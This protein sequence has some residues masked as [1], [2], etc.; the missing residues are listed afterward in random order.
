[1]SNFDLRKFLAEQKTAKVNN[2]KEETIKE[3]DAGVVAV[4][5]PIVMS[6]VAAG[7][8]KLG[9]DKIMQA[10][11]RIDKDKFNKFV[12]KYAS[13]F[14][15]GHHK[16]MEEADHDMEE[17]LNE[18]HDK[19]M[20][21][22]HDEMEEGEM[23][24]DIG[25]VVDFIMQNADKSIDWIK[26]NIKVGSMHQAMSS[27]AHDE[28]EEA[29]DEMEEGHKDMEEKKDHMEEAHKD[30]EEAHDE[31]EEVAGTAL[32]GMA[33]IIGSTAAAAKA[34]DFIK[35]K[36][37]DAVDKFVKS[38]DAR[39]KASYKRMEEEVEE[40]DGKEMEEALNEEKFK[41]TIKDILN[42]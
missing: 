29:H 11:A 42:S 37:P 23:H 18:G 2:V 38:V 32:A 30:M 8:A 27:E 13:D 9:F 4:G 12:Q 22:A 3:F 6:V 20:E 16:D 15:E 31:M 24:E 10:I 34:L 28:M 5:A 33:A 17:A 19:D 21:E 25:K 40:G 26:K 39:Q 35:K 14:E 1:M 41:S 36:Y 7:I